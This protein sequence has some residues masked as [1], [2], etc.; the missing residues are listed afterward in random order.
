MGLYRHLRILRR[1]RGWD[2]RMFEYG[3]W[4]IDVAFTRSKRS[5]PTQKQAF[6][7]DHARSRSMRL[8]IPLSACTT[9]APFSS[10]S[11]T[12]V[13]GIVQKFGCLICA[14]ESMQTTR[15]SE[16]RGRVTRGV[17]A[18]NLGVEME[19]EKVKAFLCLGWCRGESCVPAHGLQ[20]HAAGLQFQAQKC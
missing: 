5:R 13:E 11:C 17:R 4:K 20:I 15:S 1:G 16:L 7:S 2:L 9:A 3:S 8:S 18:D 6:L 10:H 12:A 14:R 19:V